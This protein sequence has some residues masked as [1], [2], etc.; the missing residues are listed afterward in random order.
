MREVK[1][2]GISTR[3][4]QFVIGSLETED[5]HNGTSIRQGGCIV[6]K[7]KPET[8]GQFTGLKDRH[9]LDIYEGDIVSC[10]DIDWPAE[11]REAVTGTIVFSNGAFCLKSG[12]LYNALWM[13]AEEIELQGNIYEHS[14]LLTTL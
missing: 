6:N 2:R 9:G 1:F 10:M 4:N 13:N 7:V 14:E 11:S 3:T 12:E 5:I 8:V